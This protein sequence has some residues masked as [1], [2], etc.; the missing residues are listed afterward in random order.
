MS[1]EIL[2]ENTVEQA[3]LSWLE[4]LGYTKLHGPDIAEDGGSPER[5]GYSDVVLKGRL[6]SAIKRLNPKLSEEGIEET[7]R[8]V[9]NPAHPSVVLNNRAFHLMLANGVEIQYRKRDGESTKSDY[10]L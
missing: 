2:N 3:T 9:L 7:L 5:N 8:K 10:S 4:E 1:P 6:E